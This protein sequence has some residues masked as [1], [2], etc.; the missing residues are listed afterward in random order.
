LTSY[1][2]REV[3]VLEPARTRQVRKVRLGDHLCLPFESEDEQ[4]EVITA[5][6]VDGLARGE[7]VIYFAD[8]TA[9]DEIGAWLA[10]TG[11]DTGRMVDEGRLEIRPIDNNYLFEGRFEPDV[12]ITTLWIEVR[13]A[14]DAGY[15]G[16]RISSEMTS[17]VGPVAGEQVL[18]EY[19]NRLARVFDSRELAAI[20][21]YDRRLFGHAAVTGMIDCHPEVVQ[22]DPLH[23]DRRLRITPTY[24]PRGLRVAGCVDLTTS[25]AL[26][27][28]L[29]HA[30]DWPERELYLDLGELEFIDVAG[31][32]AIV[33]AAGSLE[34]GRHLVVERLAP[35]L[36]RVFGLVGW[37][38]SPGL[39][40]AE[41]VDT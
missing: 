35:A 29:R 2:A 33:R 18:R 12:V 28:T 1:S 15:P 31:V 5:Y 21:Q 36:R 16:L 17:E 3:N 27:G 37:D 39:R 20:C 34:R 40:F 22:I 11:V 32:R 6:I 13:Q 10:A 24:G 25:G 7:R 4:R 41:E 26:A 14:R 23:D 9:P 30:A 19:E 38:R 8:R